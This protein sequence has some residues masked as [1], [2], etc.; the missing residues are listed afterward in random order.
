[1]AGS[2]TLQEAAWLA[3]TLGRGDLSPFS[4]SDMD[5]ISEVIG[6]VR[7]PAGTVLMTQG[8]PM[9]FI[10]LI[11]EGRVELS[12][13]RGARRVVL[14]VLHDGDVFGDIPFLCEM[15]PPFGARALTDVSVVRIEGDDPLRIIQTNPNVCHRMMFSLASRLQRTQRRLLEV[16]R[17]DLRRQIIAL[18]LDESEDRETVVSLS[19]RT[20]G[21]MLGASRQRVNQILRALEREGAVT[22]SYGRVEVLDRA[23]LSTTV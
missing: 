19:Q 18:L 9:R 2:A 10:G 1:M 6:S 8:E 4:D 13:R 3:R 21:E 20:I 12:T 16:T 14:Q 15:P 23:A 22:L 11:R 17:V 5:A 7:A